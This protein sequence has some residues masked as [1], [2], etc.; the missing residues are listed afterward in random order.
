VAQLPPGGGNLCCAAATRRLRTWS[1]GRTFPSPAR[2]RLRP[3]RRR[4]YRLG[5]VIA[6]SRGARARFANCHHVV[7]IQIKYPSKFKLP[8]RRRFQH[9][10]ESGMTAALPPIRTIGI[11]FVFRTDIVCTRRDSA[12]K[13]AEQQCQS[14]KTTHETAL[15]S[16]DEVT[17]AI[18]RCRGRPKYELLHSGSFHSPA[19]PAS[20]T[21]HGRSYVDGRTCGWESVTVTDSGRARKA[22]ARHRAAKAG[23]T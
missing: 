3:Q 20:V 22:H 1:V 8:Q 17:G 19:A 4:N 23:V 16:S 10:L 6:S 15:F 2:R 11:T 12:H 7:A 5:T 14:D 18:M 9:V 21:R 13:D